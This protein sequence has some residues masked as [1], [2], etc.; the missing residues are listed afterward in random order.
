[1]LKGGRHLDPDLL[2]ADHKGRRMSAELMQKT[3]APPWKKKKQSRRF[4]RHRYWRYIADA[5]F[6]IFQAIV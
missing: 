3:P 2:S 1:M 6:A 5:E 4:V